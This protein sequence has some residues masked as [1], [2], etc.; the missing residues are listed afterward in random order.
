M[1]TVP[2]SPVPATLNGTVCRVEQEA[3]NACCIDFM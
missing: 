1:L 3:T 2:A